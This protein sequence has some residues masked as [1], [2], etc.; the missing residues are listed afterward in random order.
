MSDTSIVHGVGVTRACGPARAD[1]ASRR[2]V[3]LFACTD[4]G[5]SPQRLTPGEAIDV[6]RAL[7]AAAGWELSGALRPGS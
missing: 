5:D 3:E 7:I 1:G 6:A 2:V 4:W